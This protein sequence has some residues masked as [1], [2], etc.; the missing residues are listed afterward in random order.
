MKKRLQ[1]FE[2]FIVKLNETGEADINYNDPE[3]DKIVNSLEKEGFESYYKEFDKYQGVYLVVKK[4][5]KSNKF[6]WTDTFSTGSW[7]DGVISS[8]LYDNDGDGEW[9]GNAGDYFNLPKDHV[10]Q[11][12]KLVYKYREDGKVKVKEID[13]PKV[14]D[15]PQVTGAKGS[16]T[17]KEEIMEFTLDKTE[18][19]I[20]YIVGS[21]DVSEFIL[22]F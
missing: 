15:L 12:T 5:G 17:P 16:F 9:S 19:T 3:M 4:N 21:G 20:Q 8:T 6:W 22:R 13:N 10:F 11:D 1:T 14:S 2:S 18:D 7:G